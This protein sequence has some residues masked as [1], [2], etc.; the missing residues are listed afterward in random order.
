MPSFS[1][2]AIDPGYV[3]LA[4]SYALGI[5]SRLSDLV[6]T[7]TETEKELVAVERCLQYVDTVPTE[8]LDLVGPAPL[9]GDEPWPDQGRVSFQGVSLRYRG[10]L[11]PALAAFSFES[12]P[13]E[14]VGIVGRT[15]SGKSSLFHALFRSAEHVDGTITLD[16]VDT[17]RLS[18]SELRRS[19]AAI[20]QEPF[21]FSGTVR[22]NLDPLGARDGRTD[23]DTGCSRK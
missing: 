6:K 23:G 12:A 10:Y 19:L 8:D 13:W 18:L 9:A 1:S 4:I 22:E 2:G 14:K 17:G 5:T 3:G 7:F 15:G 16:G 20:P 11:P 21:L